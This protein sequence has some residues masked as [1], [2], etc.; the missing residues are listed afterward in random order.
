MASQGVPASQHS[1]RSPPV[2]RGAAAALASA[3]AGGAGA[4]PLEVTKPLL[5]LKD[6]LLAENADSSDDA[7]KRAVSLRTGFSNALRNELLERPFGKKLLDGASRAPKVRVEVRATAARFLHSEAFTI[8]RAAECDVQ[9]TG[10][11][12]ASRLQLLVVSLP[13]GLVIVDAWSGGGTRMVRRSG[14][15]EVLPSSIPQHRTAIFVPHEERVTLLIGARTSVTLG[16]AVNT[17]PKTALATPRMTTKSIIEAQ[18][19]AAKA[20][21]SQLP[22]ASVPA[23]IPREVLQA[24]PSAASASEAPATAS[25]KLAPAAAGMC[26]KSINATRT[27][28]RQQQLGCHRERLRGR[29]AAAALSPGLRAT[30]EE[31]LSAPSETA[32][33]EIRDVLDGFGAPP[34]PDDPSGSSATWT[35]Q[36]CKVVQKTR[37]WQC[38]FKHRYCRACLHSRAMS[39]SAPGCPN[40]AC[41]YLLG[42][43][44]LQEL[45]VPAERIQAITAA[46]GGQKPLC[47]DEGAS[48]LVCSLHCGAAVKRP[49]DEKARKSWLC[50]CGAPPVCTA[51]GSTPYHYHGS[52]KEVRQLRKRW[53]EWAHRGGREA[54]HSLQ[55]RA[56]RKATTQKRALREAIEIGS[57]QTADSQDEAAATPAQAAKI[58]KA[59]NAALGGSGVRHLLTVCSICGSGGKGIL[60]PRFRCIHCPNFSV[61]QKCEPKLASQHPE[62]HVFQIMFEDDLDWE[63]VQTPFPRGVRARLRGNAEVATTGGATAGRKRRLS[64]EGVLRGQKRGKYQLE[65]TDG[66]GILEVTV[67]QIQPLLA[68]KQAERIEASGVLGDGPSA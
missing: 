36:A 57:Q 65:L 44:D 51:C 63:R 41:G 33:Q 17:L 5:Q 59:Q 55:R 31:H 21:P 64:S 68:L 48:Q 45:R 42:N 2:L 16:P 49:A 62:G 53:L 56:K 58:A 8:G 43:A 24:A 60:G 15:V 37:G 13:A 30:L 47:P 66:S 35:C 28:L 7:A 29:V 4:G 46:R 67:H 12:T 23:A 40:Q 52:C 6:V 22:K 32:L 3:L 19:S 1:Y 14:A 10:D 34:A 9:A 27:T 11:P 18:A 38:P 50:H 20:T 39:E 61:C 25:P 26:S 54:Y